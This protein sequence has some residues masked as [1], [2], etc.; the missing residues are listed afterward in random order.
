MVLFY[1]V[2]VN[3]LKLYNILFVLKLCTYLV[4]CEMDVG[5]SCHF[6][7]PLSFGIL[8][9]LENQCHIGLFHIR[10]RQRC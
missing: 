8:L 4:S 2:Y 9:L 3:L 10:E 7:D 5:S 6:S 1:S